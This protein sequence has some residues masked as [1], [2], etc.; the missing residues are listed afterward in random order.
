MPKPL[1]KS[2]KKKSQPAPAV[3]G[4][5]VFATAP[6]TARHHNDHSEIDAYIEATGD[7]A[8]LTKIC[9]ATGVD[10]EATANFIVRAV[11]AYDAH[12]A[13]IAELAAAL[14][15]CLDSGNLGWKTEYAAELVVRKAEQ[16]AG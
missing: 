8:T 14:R 11:N 16:T 5:S 3:Q 2:L 7:W 15:Q 4:R 9:D 13:L 10:A 12:R 1:A 6:W